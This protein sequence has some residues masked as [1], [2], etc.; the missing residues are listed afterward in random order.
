MAQDYP[1]E[2]FKTVTI[3]S[4]TKYIP[5]IL[6]VN[7]TPGMYHGNKNCDIDKNNIGSYRQIFILSGDVTAFMQGYCKHIKCDNVLNIPG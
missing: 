5:L 7:L 3:F 1:L 4:V 6:M 2:Q